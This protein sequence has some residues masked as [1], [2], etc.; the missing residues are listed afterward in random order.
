MSGNRL[1]GARWAAVISR[2]STRL[3]GGAA[4]GSLAPPEPATVGETLLPALPD[5]KLA[6]GSDAAEPAPSPVAGPLPDPVTVVP[7]GCG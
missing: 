4:M 1:R 6:A 3:Q 2:I 7:W 5:D